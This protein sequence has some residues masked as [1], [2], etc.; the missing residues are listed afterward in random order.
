[1][2]T[3]QTSENRYIFMVGDFNYDIF[4]NYIYQLNSIDSENFTNILA[5]FNIYKLIHKPTR[6]KPPS[7][8]LLENIYTNIHIIIDSCKSGILTSNIT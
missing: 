3:I 6:I 4:K 5:G 8:T 7:A 2:F 1:M